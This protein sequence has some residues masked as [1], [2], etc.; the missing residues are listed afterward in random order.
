MINFLIILLVY[1]SVC[2]TQLKMVGK[3]MNNNH[4][5]DQAYKLIPYSVTRQ[6]L[7]QDEL[8]EISGYDRHKDTRKY[9]H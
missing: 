6:V 8:A 4:M 2:L 3:T 5:D 1:Y 7:K 9:F